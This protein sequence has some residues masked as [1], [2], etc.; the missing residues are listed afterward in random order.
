MCFLL[1]CR[2]YTP[3]PA[4]QYKGRILLI[5]NINGIY[6]L[7]SD[8]LEP[9]SLCNHELPY[10]G[11]ECRGQDSSFLLASSGEWYIKKGLAP[12]NLPK[13]Q[14]LC[15]YYLHDTL[16]RLFVNF[17]DSSCQIDWMDYGYESNRYLYIGFLR[18]KH[19][20]FLLDSSLNFI[21]E[22][23][24]NALPRSQ[25]NVSNQVRFLDSSHLIYMADFDTTNANDPLRKRDIMKFDID[26]GTAQQIGRAVYLYCL[27]DDRQKALIESNKREVLWT[28]PFIGNTYHTYSIL[29]IKSGD[30]Y[31]LPETDKDIMGST[32]LSPDE[33]II[34]AVVRIWDWHWGDVYRLFIIDRIT[35]KFYGTRLY[36]QR[37]Y[38]VLWMNDSSK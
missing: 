15:R 23:G 3:L 35:G 25:A 31:D 36:S 14:C 29:D 7:E 26:K 16:P 21:R 32:A 13:C 4:H 28:L 33:K 27:S 10:Y 22:I 18:Y 11:L 9:I 30:I 20:V 37:G 5:G 8:S 1:G 34:A 38:D 24:K 17:H 12:S 2:G 6:D 19:G